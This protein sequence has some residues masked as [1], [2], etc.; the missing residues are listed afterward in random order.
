[1]IVLKTVIHR[2]TMHIEALRQNIK[3]K[4]ASFN[5]NSL[6]TRLEIVTDWLKDHQPDILCL[7]ETK[8]QDID[9]PAETFGDLGYESVH[10][11]QK[12]YNGVAI[13]SKIA[14]KKVIFSINQQY[15]DARFIKASY[16]NIT[17]VNTYVPQGDSMESEKFNYKLS[18]LN[19]LREYF[20][21]NHTPK[22]P[23]IWVGDLNVAPAPIDVYN[24]K[25]RKNHVCYCL[26]ARNA[27][28]TVV[29]WGFTDVFRMHCNEPGQY[30]F[31]DYRKKNALQNNLGWRL[32]HIMATK[33]LAKK[34]KKCYIDKKPRAA[35]RPSDHTPIIAE[36]DI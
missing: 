4:I 12:S 33:P 17:I 8:V 21:A 11:G 16:K 26:Q 3:M 28:Q 31:W 29:D 7:Q 1:M 2:P 20:E 27:M 6:R 36:F 35:A 23:I 13:F 15:K 18:W 9:F 30:T 14:L 5:T 34:C 22:D 19:S 25:K 32:D 10:I 24:P